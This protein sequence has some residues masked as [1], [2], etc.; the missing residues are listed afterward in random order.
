MNQTILALNAQGLRL[1]DP[2]VVKTRIADVVLKKTTVEE[3]L[4][5]MRR[6]HIDKA[7]EAGYTPELREKVLG[8]STQ[9]AEVANQI[10]NVQDDI[11]QVCA[12]DAQL[13][14]AAKAAQKA[15]QPMPTPR[16]HF[17][18]VIVELGKNQHEF[19]DVLDAL[20]ASG[21]FTPEIQE[22]LDAA[23]QAADAVLEGVECTQRSQM[24]GFRGSR[25]PEPSVS[26]LKYRLASLEN[27]LEAARQDAK[28][29]AES[30]NSLTR[31][32]A[33]L[34]E[35]LSSER[36]S[37]RR[38]QVDA[39]KSAAEVVRLD[40]VARQG[41][42]EATSIQ[43]DLDDKSQVLNACLETLG[44]RD[45][46]LIS[47][48]AKL[49]DSDESLVAATVK[50]G[51]RDLEIT[52]LRSVLQDREE[53]LRDFTQQLTAVQDKL[54][55]SGRQLTA[56]KDELQ[57]S[58]WQLTK[59]QKDLLDRDGR[60]L[61]SRSSLD[62]VREELSKLSVKS[63]KELAQIQSDLQ[64]RERQIQDV[65]IQS[66]QDMSM[67]QQESARKLAQAESSLR[68]RKREILGTTKQLAEAEEKLQDSNRQLT[69]LQ[70]E[71]ND[72][73][74][75]LAQEL[76]ASQEEVQASTR[77][78][79]TVRGDLNSSN[80][81][82][83]DARA[84]V[85]DLKKKLQDLEEKL[86]DSALELT[87]GRAEMAETRRVDSRKTDAAVSVTTM[88]WLGSDWDLKALLDKVSQYPFTEASS[89]PSR[90]W[91]MLP[92]LS[93]DESLK[94]Q[95][96]SRK[97]EAIIVDALASVQAGDIPKLWGVLSALNGAL[98]ELVE[99]PL[100]VVKMLLESLADI[101]SSPDLHLAHRVAIGIVATSL[102]NAWPMTM[103]RVHSVVRA[104]RATDPKAAGVING[105][106]AD[107]P[108]FDNSIES[109]HGL[110]VG[111]NYEPRG[112]LIINPDNT[113]IR[114]VD[115]VKHA[116]GKVWLG[117]DMM[118]PLPD[119][120]RLSWWCKHAFD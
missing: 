110:L 94:P 82:L 74:E 63:S 46:E 116:S 44:Q 29:K 1:F 119:I 9:F 76:A 20:G 58:K 97:A 111:F 60:L 105:L 17:L 75:K 91:K 103:S 89:A 64:D 80:R 66:V 14:E 120:D 42:V 106:Y 12:M 85:R 7:V 16:D 25:P 5:K 79:A 107:E 73:V 6:G 21:S 93:S 54:Q 78:I 28:V 109:S 50:L 72:R 70:A 22:M 49:R 83:T 71:S 118:L 24:L 77:V 113:T 35:E 34:R 81:Q 53:K 59:A 32:V 10:R 51:A 13:I 101:V 99:V 102:G 114:W 61:D 84:E 92:P 23:G 4:K 67:Q 38:L 69:D 15:G 43:L 33:D 19:Q 95:A 86:R 37:A 62:R 27:E 88:V 45:E 48:K 26:G 11:D 3:A 115:K 30:V 104:I 100:I 117:E 112:V 40:R 8:W 87:E 18:Q 96:D 90:L 2:Q 52:A 56:V 108:M 39:T 98:E 65:T 41:R 68:D 47:T 57:D 55:A 31:D 36:A